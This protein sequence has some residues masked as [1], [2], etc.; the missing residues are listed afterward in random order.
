MGCVQLAQGGGDA[1]QG[2]VRDAHHPVVRD[3]QHFDDGLAEQIVGKAA[4]Q[5]AGEVGHPQ[6]GRTAQH[7]LV[8]IDQL[9]AIQQ[10]NLHVLVVEE[11]VRVDE[12]DVVVGQVQ[13]Q[14]VVHV[15]EQVAADGT[16]TVLVQFQVS[17]RTAD[18]IEEAA[19]DLRDVVVGQIQPTDARVGRVTGP[20][21]GQFVDDVVADVHYQRGQSAHLDDKFS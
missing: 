11:R 19:C 7:V 21:H 10:Q 9:V 3:V 6:V 12:L 20:V 2:A 18:R 16:Q 14:Q 13:P 5:V 17:Q 8:N 15:T 1:N 4:Q